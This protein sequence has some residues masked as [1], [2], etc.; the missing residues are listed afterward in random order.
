MESVR[1]RKAPVA[2]L[3]AV[4]VTG[5]TACGD[6]GGT[7]VAPTG[8]TPVVDTQSDEDVARKSVDA[9]L[10]LIDLG[11]Y[12]EA[13]DA[14][15]SFF[16]ENVTAEDFRS[17]LEEGRAALGALESRTVRSAQRT[18]TLPDAPPGDYL[19]FE[20]DAVFELRP[21]TGERVTAVSEGDEWPVVGYYIIR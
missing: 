4:V 9:W 11:N 12:A 6:A 21:D 20:F 13:Y 14:T 3:L 15:G 8:G 16:R 10:S 19:V 1:S 7:P 5:F 18:T 2:M 17:Q